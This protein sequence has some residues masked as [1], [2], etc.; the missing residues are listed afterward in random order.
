[1]DCRQRVL[2]ALRCGQPDRVPYMYSFIDTKLQEQIVG[3]ELTEYLFDLDRTRASS[4]SR[5][6]RAGFR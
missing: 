6:S 2:T 3:H 5:A 4:S 1:M